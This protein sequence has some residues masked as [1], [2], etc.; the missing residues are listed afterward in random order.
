MKA[1]INTRTIRLLSALLVVL[2]TAVYGTNA[3]SAKPKRSKA[4]KAKTSKSKKTSAQSPADTYKV[5][6]LVIP[7]SPY[8]LEPEAPANLTRLIFTDSWEKKPTQ[9]IIRTP[10]GQWKLFDRKKPAKPKII[11]QDVSVDSQGNI[12]L[13]YKKL[14]YIYH[15]DKAT[16]EIYKN[17]KSQEQYKILTD[18]SY[19]PYETIESLYIP[20][21]QGYSWQFSDYGYMVRHGNKMVRYIP[22]LYRGVWSV[23]NIESIDE[24]YTRFKDDDY[25]YKTDFPKGYARNNRSADF[26]E[27]T[28]WLNTDSYKTRGNTTPVSCNRTSDKK[29][30]QS[31]ISRYLASLP[32]SSHSTLGSKGHLYY[33]NNEYICTTDPS[34]NVWDNYNNLRNKP[35]RRLYRRGETDTIIYLSTLAGDTLYML[36]RVKGVHAS[37]L[38]THRDNY[39]YNRFD[40][41]NTPCRE[42]YITQDSLYA[43]LDGYIIRTFSNNGPVSVYEMENASDADP[44]AVPKGVNDKEKIDLDYRISIT[45]LGETSPYYRKPAFPFR[46]ETWSPRPKIKP[47][48]MIAMEKKQAKEKRE[49]ELTAAKRKRENEAAAARRRQKNKATEQQATRQS[50]KPSTNGR[51]TSSPTSNVALPA[52]GMFPKKATLYYKNEKGMMIRLMFSDMR[53]VNF[54][55]SVSISVDC[56]QILFASLLS[57]NNNIRR[58]G[59]YFCFYNNSGLNINGPLKISCDWRTVI[60]GNTCYNQPVTQSQYNDYCTAMSKN[61]VMS[62]WRSDALRDQANTMREINE[63]NREFRDNMR[64]R[65]RAEEQAH[66]NR[67]HTCTHCHGTGANPL[68]ESTAPS[69]TIGIKH[70]NPAGNECPY[71]KGGPYHNQRYTKHWHAQCIHCK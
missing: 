71:C 19:Y 66:R 15:P 36:P 3:F 45:R 16:L 47:A 38:T 23:A 67:R 32:P 68:P 11:F 50:L 8:S 39:E 18:F 62:Q 7:S 52:Y 34:N 5:P 33:I 37:V 63:S 17:N 57:N 53:D 22:S 69:A 6:D 44:S 30:F 35:H 29:M 60:C 14:S 49:R 26:I 13:K 12:T 41:F 31:V 59:D 58:E 4:S 1:L 64:T 56:N 43:A 54:L 21:R 48:R 2:L 70:Y 9:I 40:Y 25:Q 55:W 61:P 46:N 10:S 65:E 27:F 24:R 42:L 51:Q 28:T 20:S